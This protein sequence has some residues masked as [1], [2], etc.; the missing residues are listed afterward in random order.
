[1]T[2]VLEPTL[3]YSSAI[4]R[5]HVHRAAICE[6]FLTDIIC[7][8]YPQ[9]RLGVQLPR[10]HS[11]YSDHNVVVRQYD[12]L[13]LLE[14][15]RQASILISHRHVDA[16]LDAKFVFNAGALE[17]VDLDAVKVGPAPAAGVLD[18]TITAEKRRGADIVGITLAMTLALD[19]SAAATMSMTIQWMPGDAWDRLRQRGRAPL[20]LDPARPHPLHERVEPR[21][22]ARHSFDNV[23]LSR[24]GVDGDTVRSQVLVDQAH[25][26]L[27]DHPLD[28]VPGALIFE[29]MRQTALVAA[30]ELFG[31]S[32]R[33]LVLVGCDAVFESFGEL[34]LPTD[35]AAVAEA[36][37]CS[38]QVVL[39][40]T[41]AQEGRQIAHGRVT[42]Q[43]VSASTAALDR[44]V[45]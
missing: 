8:S 16:P 18:A 37:I 14:T 5:A 17:V 4:P 34:E 25:P 33:M 40:V 32:P 3:S 24:I 11:Y 15:F 6:V 39:S 44:I 30:H 21:E 9:F 31:L 41:L 27:F 38:R 28:H 29:A 19:G 1:M 7:E 13:L 22:V 45:R 35:C 26:G 12:P 36:E 2:A 43:R 23:V 10:V 20:Q 42:L